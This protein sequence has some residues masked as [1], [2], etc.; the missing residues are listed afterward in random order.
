MGD[1]QERKSSNEWI[2]TREMLENTPSI[3]YGYSMIA[4]RQQRSKSVW[5]IKDLAKELRW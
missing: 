2:F 5:F 3:Q 4:E 1:V